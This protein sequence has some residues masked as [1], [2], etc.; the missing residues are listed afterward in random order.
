MLLSALLAMAALSHSVYLGPG[1][2]ESTFRLHEPVGVILLFRA[3][4]P[5][6]AKVRV[7]GRIPNV[8]GV[9]L[10]TTRR[11]PSLAAA[12]TAR[13]LQDRSASTSWSGTVPA[14]SEAGRTRSRRVAAR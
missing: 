10:V 14:G 13:Q 8:A 5:H 1:H 11:M 6:G 12:G 9:S 4:V 2:A 7:D 3:T